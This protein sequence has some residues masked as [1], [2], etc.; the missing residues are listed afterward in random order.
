[1]NADVIKILVQNYKWATIDDIE[2]ILHFIV[3]KR[4]NELGFDIDF[5]V[6]YDEGGML[7]SERTSDGKLQ[8]EIG[9]LPFCKAREDKEINL[10]IDSLDEKKEFIELILQTFHELRH[11][12]QINSIID[13]PIFNEETFRMS[14][15]LIINESFP[16]FINRFNYESSISEIDA[17]KTSLLDKV[18]FFQDMESDITPDEVFQV[19]K[20]KEL[21]YLN[22]NVQNFGSSCVTAVNYFNQICC[23][24]KEIKGYPEVLQ[25]LTEEEKEIFNNQCHDLQI[26]YNLETSVEE[27]LNILMEMSLMLKPELYEK[28]PLASFKNHK[29]I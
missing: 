21:C 4:I 9:I 5:E 18:K 10:E 19:M 22:Y 6:V 20:E 25:L 8:L 27:K 1:M 2:E 26:S 13:N 28:Y 17:M 3:R 11:I 14:R 16:G 7:K 24:Q 15:E 23:N 12:V 29:K